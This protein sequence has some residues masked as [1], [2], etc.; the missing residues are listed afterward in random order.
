MNKLIKLPALLFPEK[1]KPRLK[2]VTIRKPAALGMTT[3]IQLLPVVESKMI[4]E[5]VLPPWGFHQ[6]NVD[7]PLIT[8]TSTLRS[9]A[10][11][12][13]SIKNVD[14][15]NNH[16]KIDGTKYSAGYLISQL[17]KKK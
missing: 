15:A 11:D 13:A 3:N 14:Y 8:P 7:L 17:N 5:G 2:R 1:Y 12:L 9:V 4:A 10:A 6:G 16:I